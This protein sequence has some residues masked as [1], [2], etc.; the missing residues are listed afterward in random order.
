[1]ESLVETGLLPA[2]FKAVEW[3][4]PEN[5]TV[6]D[7]PSGYVVSLVPFHERGVDSPGSKF[8]RG[9]LHHYEIEPQHS[10]PNGVL[11]IVLF[12]TLSPLAVVACV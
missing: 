4:I 2:L 1:M 12:V 6:P 3:I 7:P 5:E 10:N 8:L 11:H 9:L